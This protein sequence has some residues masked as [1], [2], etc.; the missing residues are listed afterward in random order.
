MTASSP[1]YRMSNMTSLTDSRMNVLLSR[2]IVICMSAGS[3]FSMRSQLPSGSPRQPGRC[4]SPI[5]SGCSIR[6]PAVPLTRARL[7]RSLTP[8]T[9]SATSE[10]W[11]TFPPG[12]ATITLLKSS[13]LVIFSHRAEKKLAWALDQVSGRDFHVRRGH[14][15]DDILNGEV[16]RLQP[17]R[18]DL[19]LDFPLVAADEVHRP[20]PD[21][22]EPFLDRHPLRTW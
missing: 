18:I 3:S 7:V 1:P 4:C 16:V 9:T 2:A 20:R 13:T 8:S 22:L 12:V 10:R 11:T 6:P 15:L 21:V 19:D 17:G 5:A 14:A